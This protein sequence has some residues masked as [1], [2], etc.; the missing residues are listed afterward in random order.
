MSAAVNT[1]TQRSELSLTDE[2]DAFNKLNICAGILTASI[3]FLITLFCGLSAQAQ[4]LDGLWL[5]DGSGMLFDI[6]GETVRAFDI[7]SISCLPSWRVTG[8]ANPA[9][10]RGEMIFRE[11]AGMRRF[12]LDTTPNIARL[13]S[14]C[15]T[16]DIFFRKMQQPPKSYPERVDNTPQANYAIFWQTFAENYPFFEL[17]HVN[18]ADVDREFRPQVTAQTSPGD[19]FRIL[20]RMIE[21]LHDAH[22]SVNAPDLKQQFRGSRADPNPLKYDDWVQSAVIIASKYVR[23]DMQYFCKNQISFG[24]LDNSIGYMKI[25]SFANYADDPD[26]AKQVQ[27]LEMALDTIFH[28]S[29]KLRGL[30]IDVRLNTGGYDGLGLSIASRLAKEDYLAYSVK[31]FNSTNGILHF[32]QPQAVWIHASTRP[33]F[34]GNV[35]VLTGHNCVSASETF[36][37][38]LLGRKPIVSRVGENTQGVFSDVL[39]RRLPNGWSFGLPNEIYLTEDGKAFDGL[40]VPPSLSVPVFPRQDFQN[41]HDT[42]LEKAVQVLSAPGN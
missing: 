14:D 7:T 4:T 15:S 41:K 1:N 27:A 8:N 42:A 11:N 33:G 6:K 32:T 3:V 30:A 23:G 35:V 2:R 16:A 9:S 28:D 22:T 40:G 26:Y 12:T 39:T 19:L 29:G 34:R 13:Q 38:S 17:H 20:R 25:W 21:P 24:M 18:W 5:S 10:G 36:V 31:T 37:M